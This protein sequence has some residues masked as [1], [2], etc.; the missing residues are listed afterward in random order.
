MFEN[1]RRFRYNSGMERIV[2]IGGGGHAK[3]V[4]DVLERQG[5]YEIAGYL[6]IHQPKGHRC[7][8]YENID[9]KDDFRRV[10]KDLGARGGI[11]AVGDNAKRAHLAAAV[12]AVLPEFHFV[13]AVHP[14]AILGKHV[15][16]GAGTVVMA[17]VVINPETRIGDHGIINTRASL[18]H[19]NLIGS[20]VS[21]APG[22][23]TGGSV[24]V[25]DYSAVGLGANIIHGVAVGEHAVIGAGSTV[26][27]S[28]P[29]FVVAFGSPA[30]V[31]RSR[32]PGE[33]YLT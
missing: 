3:A 15:V 6:D 16:I 5:R 33:D 17:G 29:A 13:T 20:Y 31:Q 11:I 10:A 22:V 30:K 19:D 2:V 1:A 23:T 4:I 21:I 27:E 12:R 7:L 25:G 28:I 24:S 32:K 18:D 9:E 8:G 14:S 26:I